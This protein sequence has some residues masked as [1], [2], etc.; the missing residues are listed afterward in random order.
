MLKQPPASEAGMMMMM[1]GQ[2]SNCLVHVGQVFQT[3]FKGKSQSR[4]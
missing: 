2:V 3:Y 4:S 1:T